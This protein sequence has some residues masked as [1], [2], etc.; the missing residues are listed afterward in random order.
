MI[1]ECYFDSLEFDGLL[2]FMIGSLQSE[3]IGIVNFLLQSLLYDYFV[4]L[5]SRKIRK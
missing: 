4:Y 5:C 2:L 3:S 1:K